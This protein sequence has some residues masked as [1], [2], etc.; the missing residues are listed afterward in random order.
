MAPYRHRFRRWSL[1][2]ACQLA[3]LAAWSASPLF[4]DTLHLKNGRRIEVERYWEEGNQLFY[5]KNGSTF[6]FS[7]SLL[8]RVGRGE[9]RPSPPETPQPPEEPSTGFRN[10][11]SARAVAHA[12]ASAQGGELQEAARYYRQALSA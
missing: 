8:E 4:S 1:C 3:L 12:R 7:L 11:P 10:E 9:A 6:G 5:V 2:L